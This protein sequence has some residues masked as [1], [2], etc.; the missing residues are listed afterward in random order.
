MR[1]IRR[2]YAASTIHEAHVHDCV[3]GHGDWHAWRRRVGLG[4]PAEGSVSQWSTAEHLRSGVFLRRWCAEGYAIR[5]LLGRPGRW[6]AAADHDRTDVCPVP[7]PRAA[8]EVAAHHDPRVDA[9]GSG[10]GFD[11]WR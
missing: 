4:E 9:Y 3:D 5:Q 1:D 8:T 7:D 6:S 11:T 10:T 2:I